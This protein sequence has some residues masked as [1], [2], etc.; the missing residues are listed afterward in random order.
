[1]PDESK[2]SLLE[3][4]SAAAAALIVCGPGR[5]HQYKIMFN[6]GSSKRGESWGIWA[7]SS[8]QLEDAMEEERDRKRLR[9]EDTCGR[10]GTR[11]PSLVCARKRLPVKVSVD[12]HQDDDDITDRPIKRFK[13][14]CVVVAVSAPKQKTSETKPQS[15]LL[16]TLPE[17]VMSH[18][19]SFLNT[20]DDR[21]SLQTTCKQFRR[22][23]NSD[24]MLV[25][26]QVGGDRE[27]GKNG[28][29]QEDDTPETAAVVLAPFSRAGNLEA[30]Y[31]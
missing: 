29:I 12:E 28:I 24:K 5:G 13:G 1:M 9:E 17:D 10:V 31:M 14:E 22:I 8:G 11:T 27:T 19:L 4:V 20:V 6:F 16:G 3:A 25:N 23:S 26:I 21:F 30:I 18:C 15:G 2:K 7:Q